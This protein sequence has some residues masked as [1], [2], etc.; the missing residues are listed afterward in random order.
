[1]K[2]TFSMLC[3][4]LILLLAAS[5]GGGGSSDEASCNAT[6]CTKTE[7]PPF[8]RL[9]SRDNGSN[10]QF[11]SSV[12]IAPNLL[13][14]A[15]HCVYGNNVSTSAIIDNAEHQASGIYVHPSY[16]GEDISKPF[17]IAVLSFSQAVFSS[18]LPLLISDTTKAE[19][20]FSF[21]GYG[22]ENANQTPTLESVVNAP[23]HEYQMTASFII[24]NF[25]D[26]IGA[27]FTASEHLLCYGDSGG[28]A[29]RDA[30]KETGIIGIA[31]FG[32]FSNCSTQSSSLFV[33]TQRQEVLDFIIQTTT[34]L[35]I[36][37]RLI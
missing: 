18:Y 25:F 9:L 26:M 8:I 6:D 27:S 22:R 29:V 20:E 32:L 17:D 35:G 31:S 12:A 34:Q 1:M 28:A 16:T 24:A 7:A 14:T 2:N 15:A 33:N 5:C 37:L 13:L 21:F 36:S 19:D 11:C 30:N 4:F 10:I 23:L 3:L